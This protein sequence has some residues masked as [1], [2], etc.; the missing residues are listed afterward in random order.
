MKTN[1][2]QSIP[3]LKAAL[4][5]QIRAAIRSVSPDERTAASRL[6]CQRLEQFSIWRDADAILFYAPLADEVDVWP[7]L[8]VALAKGKMIALPRFRANQDAYEACLLTNLSQDLRPGNFGVREPSDRCPV[9]PINQLDLVL[10]PGVAFAVDGHRLGRGKGYYDRLL[11]NVR[12]AKCGLAFEQQVVT[13]IPAEP[14]D[15]ILDYIVTPTRL[16]AIGPD[17]AK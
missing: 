8:A 14:H 17:A 9:I 10:V 3:E 5:S 7:L 11:A 15:R 1:P 2:D 16:V 4:R 12:G 13:E 6:V